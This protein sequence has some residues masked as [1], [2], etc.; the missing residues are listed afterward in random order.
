[1][2]YIFKDEALTPECRLTEWS[3]WSSCSVTCG[4]GIKTRR[5]TYLMPDKAFRYHCNERT[6]DMISCHLLS[7]SS[8]LT[9]DHLNSSHNSMLVFNYYL[10]KIKLKKIFLGVW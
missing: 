10:N 1:L 6:Y 9:T 2:I 4:H 8:L 7:C 5:R 3:P